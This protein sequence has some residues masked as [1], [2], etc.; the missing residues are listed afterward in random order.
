VACADGARIKIKPERREYQSASKRQL[1]SES[2][3]MG[4]K[5]GWRRSSRTIVDAEPKPKPNLC[6]NHTQ[7][8]DLR[9]DVHGLAAHTAVLGRDLHVHRLQ[10]L[11]FQNGTPDQTK[12]S[13]LVRLHLVRFHT[14]LGSSSATSAFGQAPRHFG[15]SSAT[16]AFGQEPRQLWFLKCNVCIWTGT[17]PTWPTLVPQVQRRWL[18]NYW[19]VGMLECAPN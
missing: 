7:T 1:M 9:V 4:P 5:C 18:P 17:T 3:F 15:S 6:S 13:L 10:F 19:N 2:F 11:D 8:G 16:S 14:N 12:I